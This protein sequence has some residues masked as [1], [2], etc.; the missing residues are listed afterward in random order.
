MWGH[1]LSGM[2]LKSILPALAVALLLCGC[3]GGADKDPDGQTPSAPKTSGATAYPLKYTNC[4]TDVTVE[5]SPQRAVSLNQSATELML[6][7][8]LGDR[9]AGTAYQTN[10]IPADLAAAYKRVPLLS[11]GIVKHETLLNTQPD[12]VYSSYASF[13]KEE[14]A[15]T[16]QELQD[17]GVPTYLTEFDCTYHESVKGGAD[18]DMLFDEVGQ[19][20]RIF[21]VQRAGDDLVA[22]QRKVIDESVAKAKRITGTPKLVWFYSTAASKAT[23]SVAGPGGLPQTVTQMVGA[24]NLFDDGDT[25]W[26]EV[27]WDEV[28]DRNPD[29]IILG[30]LTRGYPGDT[31]KEKIDF[32]KNDPLTKQM[33][34]VK[35]NRFITISGPEMDPGLDSVQAV[36]HVSEGLLKIQD[37]EGR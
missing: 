4:G 24:K 13:F 9:L 30:D 2:R 27:S 37:E 10:P 32:L 1:T 19:I 25:K 12:F 15:G 7:L 8:G 17:L 22:Q 35:H 6:R 18:F 21:D 31:A 5:R 26:P 33:D 36:K 11:D 29:V 23:P 34:A 3:S 28:A 20:S 14:N 16:R